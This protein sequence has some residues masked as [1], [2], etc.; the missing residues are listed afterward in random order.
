MT[1]ESTGLNDP[2]PEDLDSPRARLKSNLAGVALA[3]F[4]VPL[5]LLSGHPNFA[6]ALAFVVGFSAGWLVRGA[7]DGHMFQNIEP[8]AT[9]S[10]VKK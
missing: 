7:R 8:I 4:F 6:A 2:D 3:F 5:L 9:N 10:G 1:F